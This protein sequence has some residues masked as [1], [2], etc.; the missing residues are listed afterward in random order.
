MAKTEA[1]WEK[2]GTIEV[3]DQRGSWSSKK[4]DDIQEVEE[5]SIHNIEDHGTLLLIIR[6]RIYK[7]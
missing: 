4:I 5:I 6:E 3:V 2:W 7:Y 1:T